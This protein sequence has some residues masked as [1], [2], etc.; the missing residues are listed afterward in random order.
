M[1][2][3]RTGEMW[4]HYSVKIRDMDAVRNLRQTILGKSLLFFNL[5]K[6]EKINFYFVRDGYTFIESLY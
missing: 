1:L 4:P 3:L 5:N 6:S 2:A